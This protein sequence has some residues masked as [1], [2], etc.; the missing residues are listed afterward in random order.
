MKGK[1]K[2]KIY[3]DPLTGLP[4]F[5]KF[6]ELDTVNIFQNIG[7][8]IIFDMVD[9]NTINKKY[10]KEIGDTILKTLSEV[11]NKIL[12][13]QGNFYLFRTDGDEFTVIL[14][15]ASKDY[16]E[17][18]VCEIK[19]S[20]NITMY[21]QGLYDIGVHTLILNY[22]NGI[23]SINEFYEMVLKYSL[24]K[25][26]EKDKKFSQERWLEHII[27]SFTRRI[28][29][30]LSFFNDAYNLALTDDVSGLSN[31]RAAKIYLNQLIEEYRGQIKEFCILF[32][33]GDNLKRYNQMSYEAGNKMINEL[34]LLIGGSVRENDKVFRWLSGD[35]FLVILDNSSYLDALKV[36]E[37]IRSEVEINTKEWIYPITV[38]IGVANYPADGSDMEEIIKKSEQANYKAKIT[39]KNKVIT[40]SK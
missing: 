10:G 8:F 20:F 16:A 37:R 6:I 15:Q 26:S 31:H 11:L 5:F 39:G 19:E 1:H 33:D 25:I 29:E 36:A 30:T 18:I 38:S 32:I 17:K 28:K 34:A 22:E 14:P 4:N 35:E 2:N 24:D 12:K 21:H 7:S 27:R 40:W 23:S 13:E 3:I 9:F